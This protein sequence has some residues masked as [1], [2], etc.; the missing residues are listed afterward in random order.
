VSIQAQIINLLE[1][2]QTKFNLTYFY[3]TRPLRGTSYFRPR[4][5]NVSW[6]DRRIDRPQFAI[7]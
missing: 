4:S 2:L 1:E 3:C 6:Q 7:Q 5:S